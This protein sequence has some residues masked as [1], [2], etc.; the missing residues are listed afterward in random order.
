MG[1]ILLAGCLEQSPSC[2]PL[3]VENI[4]LSELEKRFPMKVGTNLETKDW[5]DSSQFK[6]ECLYLQRPEFDDGM[7]Y[8]E[9]RESRDG[10][11]I[12]LFSPLGVTDTL[13]GFIR[14]GDDTDVVVVGML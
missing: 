11:K 10:K 5:I 1:P 3:A 4:W 14:R 7:D 8:L 9:T 13:I 6:A 2:E 12:Y